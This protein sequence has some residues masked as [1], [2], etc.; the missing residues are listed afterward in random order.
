MAHLLTI[1]HA[2]AAPGLD[3]REMRGL[4]G[5]DAELLVLSPSEMVAAVER[6]RGNR[7]EVTRREGARER[8]GA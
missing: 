1:E 8:A 3:Y 2:E 6:L 4:G 7:E 5:A